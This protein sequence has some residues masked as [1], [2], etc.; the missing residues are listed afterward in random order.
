M[1]SG[2]KHHGPTCLA[3]RVE[4]RKKAESRHARI[5]SIV[6]TEPKNQVLDGFCRSWTSLVLGKVALPLFLSLPTF[7]AQFFIHADYIFL[8]PFFFV[9]VASRLSPLPPLLLPSL[10]LLSG[11]SQEMNLMMKEHEDWGRSRSLR[12]S[13]RTPRN[14]F[15]VRSMWCFVI[16][17]W[18]NLG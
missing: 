17:L 18:L 2:R 8:L 1:I 16:R 5:F 12:P 15:R 4:G 10:F 6:Q 11:R 9:F 3:G 13:R 7:R 14:S